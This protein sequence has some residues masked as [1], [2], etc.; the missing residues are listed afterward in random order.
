RR[1]ARAQVRRGARGA[2]SG[3][4]NEATSDI[5]RPARRESGRPSAAARAGRT[6]ASGGRAVL[7]GFSRA[8]P[9]RR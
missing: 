3:G 8:A 6:R 7:P 5:I 1:G 9:G 2:A 4:L